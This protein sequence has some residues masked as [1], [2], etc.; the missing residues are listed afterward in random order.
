MLPTHLCSSRMCFCMNCRWSRTT[1]HRFCC[2]RCSALRLGRHS[3]CWLS[4]SRRLAHCYWRCC[5]CLRI[6]GEVCITLFWA[7][8]RRNSWGEDLSGTTSCWEL[9]GRSLGFR[10]FISWLYLFAWIVSSVRLEFWGHGRLTFICL[11]A[12]AIC[13]RGRTTRCPLIVFQISPS[14]RNSLL[15]R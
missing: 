5:S 11:P 1:C 7:I 9:W 3:G 2:M 13:R 14:P 8:L 15:D 4:I 12:C 10:F 6:W